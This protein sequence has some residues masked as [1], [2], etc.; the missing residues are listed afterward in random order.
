MLFATGWRGRNTG[1][2]RVD[3]HQIVPPNVA[4]GSACRAANVTGTPETGFAK[5]V[6]YFRFKRTGERRSHRCR[7]AAA[8]KATKEDTGPA[9]LVK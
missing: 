3:D 4:L 8:E 7:F 2:I 1:A 9:V 6:R 5:R